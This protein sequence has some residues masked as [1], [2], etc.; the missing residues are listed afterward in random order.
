VCRR[1]TTLLN[2]EEITRWRACHGSRRWRRR[3]NDEGV[4]ATHGMLQA[5]TAPPATM[6]ERRK[7]MFNR[8]YK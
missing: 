4:H 1:T 5:A 7:A 3:L 2:V 6:Q 8:G